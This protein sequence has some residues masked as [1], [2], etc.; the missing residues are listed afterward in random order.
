[1]LGNGFPWDTNTGLL[2]VSPCTNRY[3]T[4]H[5]NLNS[6]EIGNYYNYYYYRLSVLAKKTKHIGPVS[7]TRLISSQE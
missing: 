1:M 3:P 2:S 7:Q 6:R 4:C 5:A